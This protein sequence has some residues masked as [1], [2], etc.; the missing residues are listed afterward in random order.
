MKS[1]VFDSNVLFSSLRSK[2]SALLS[3]FERRN[4]F[5]FYTPNFLVVEIFKH[6]ERL[7]AKS[8]LTEDEFLELLSILMASIRFYNETMISGGNLLEA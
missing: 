7:R 5:Q 1:V 8:R 4:D 2:N 6:R 3:F